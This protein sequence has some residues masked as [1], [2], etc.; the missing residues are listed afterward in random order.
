LQQEQQQQMVTVL[1]GGIARHT[2]ARSRI[3]LSVLQPAQQQQ[4]VTVQVGAIARHTLAGSTALLL[5]ALQMERQVQMAAR[6]C[7]SVTAHLV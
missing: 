2:L 5:S 4:M 3:Q 7:H 6:P 1:V